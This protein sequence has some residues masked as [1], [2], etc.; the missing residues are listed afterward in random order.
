MAIRFKPQNP[1]FTDEVVCSTTSSED[2]D[3]LTHLEHDDR[4]HRYSNEHQEQ[5]HQQEPQP[6]RKQPSKSKP[7]PISTV[8]IDEFLDVGLNN[9]KSL[10]DVKSIESLALFQRL[11]ENLL[12]LTTLLKTSPDIDLSRILFQDIYA[13]ASDECIPYLL[14]DELSIVGITKQSSH[15]DLAQ[16]TEQQLEIQLKKSSKIHSNFEDDSSS[17]IGSLQAQPMELSQSMPSLSSSS[18]PLPSSSSMDA[19]NTPTDQNTAYDQSSLQPEQISQLLKKFY[20]LQPPALTIPAYLDRINQY[21]TPSTSA[22][23]T[24]AYYLFNIAFNLS[25][26]RR[27][28]LLPFCCPT[29]KTNSDGEQKNCKEEVKITMAPMDNLNIFR[30]ILTVLRISLKLIEDKNFNQAY[31]CKITGLQHVEDLFKMELNML[32][33]L[34]FKTFINEFN[35]IRF[36]FQFKQFDSNLREYLSNIPVPT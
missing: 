33:L 6:Q 9:L 25:P 20:L 11:I 17:S 10:N 3:T 27:S 13:S 18:L 2:S 35:L 15:S 1:T 7:P 16:E 34:E 29:M 4:K 5:H 28:S 21:S 30:L 32:Y 26:V 8:N 19:E 23:L 14:K 12:H 31:Y 24:A 22:T 36:L